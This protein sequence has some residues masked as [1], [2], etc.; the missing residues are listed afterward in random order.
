MLDMTHG[1]VQENGVKNTDPDLDVDIS[2]QEDHERNLKHRCRHG[3]GGEIKAH[4]RL[5][6]SQDRQNL[7]VA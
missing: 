7:K 3:G 4:K 6:V 1:L 5:H 2:D